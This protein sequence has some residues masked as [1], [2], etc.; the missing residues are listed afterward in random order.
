MAQTL[1]NI[2]L[3]HKGECCTRQEKKPKLSRLNIV[4]RTIQSEEFFDYGTIGQLVS[5]GASVRNLLDNFHFKEQ[6][7][8][9][10]DGLPRDPRVIGE[11]FLIELPVWREIKQCVDEHWN[12]F[13]LRQIKPSAGVIES[14]FLLGITVWLFILCFGH[15]LLYWYTWMFLT[16]PIY[17]NSR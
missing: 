9:V 11:L 5:S 16:V 10:R 8:I 14:E 17:V 7:E 13:M 2:I 12:A 15:P 4:E 3:S 1:C 6:W